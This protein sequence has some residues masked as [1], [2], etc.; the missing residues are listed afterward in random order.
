MTQLI[1]GYVQTN[2]DLLK[3]I[4]NIDS[5]ICQTNL[6]YAITFFHIGGHSLT[7]KTNHAL[8]TSK[9]Q[10]TLTEIFSKDFTHKE[11]IDQVILKTARKMIY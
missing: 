4:P 6:I 5:I 1:H 10:S 9:T 11:K 8:C 2:R 3:V 7:V